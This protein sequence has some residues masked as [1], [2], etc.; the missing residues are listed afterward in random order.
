MQHRGVR[1]EEG[2]TE[3]RTPGYWS[4]RPQASPRG[5]RTSKA[6]PK[7]MECSG[8]SSTE[9]MVTCKCDIVSKPCPT[10]ERSPPTHQAA[11]LD[12]HGPEPPP[13][14]SVI[15]LGH[16]FCSFNQAGS[17]ASTP[18]CQTPSVLLEGSR[19]FHPPVH[20]LDVIILPS[21]PS[22]PCVSSTDGLSPLCYT[23]ALRFSL[24]RFPGS[25][26]LTGLQ[27]P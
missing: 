4:R 24:T 26:T 16:V 15:L 23:W 7:P 1:Q 21:A 20:Q 8:A 19:S 14:S 3:Q 22:G 18:L 6:S 9:V 5:K 27:V 12:L 13:P 10:S 17:L 2:K 25:G 11:R